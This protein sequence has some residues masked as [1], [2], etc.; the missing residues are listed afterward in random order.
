MQ[1]AFNASSTSGLNPDV[2]DGQVAAVQASDAFFVW[3]SMPEST[4]WV[5]LNP[6]EPNR[7]ID[8]MLGTTDV[9][10]ILLEA[11][12]RMKRVVGRLIHPDTELG[13]KFWG[14]MSDS[15]GCIDMRQWIVPAP[16]SVYEQ[17]GGLY[18]VDA[19]LQVKMETEYL[20]QQGKPTS[21]I[22]PDKGMEN[23][24]RTLV[25][26]KLEET[27]N[28]GPEFVELRRVYLSRVAAGWYRERHSQGGTLS[29]MIDSG[30]VTVWPALKNWSPR[31]V[32]D[33]YVEAYQKKE[34][35]ITRQ[36]P[37]GNMIYEA[38]YTYGGVDF[39]KVEL[40]KAPQALFQQNHANLPAT[41]QRSIQQPAPDEHGKV[42]LG[43]VSHPVPLPDFNKPDSPTS[44]PFF[45]MLIAL[46]VIS[47]LAIGAWLLYRRHR[48]ITSP[49]IEA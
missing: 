23:R 4:F 41:V 1:Y 21:C 38:T 45:Y 33:Q 3:L 30:D 29:S 49:V 44:N 10:R 32:F 6:N 20:K 5:N 18:I 16:A 48:R 25:L 13:R 7:I 14:A 40:N 24:F 34:F 11:D 12:F 15:G 31:Q 46:P 36:V 35:N 28:H 22:T 9:G 39:S 27:I 17:D 2:A 42:W 26:P 8:D 37:R 47:W 43:A 19:P